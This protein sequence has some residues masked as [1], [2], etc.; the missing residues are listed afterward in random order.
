AIEKAVEFIRRNE[1]SAEVIVVDDGS[2]DETLKIAQEV[3]ARHDNV[4]TLFHW[5]NRG[6]GYAVRRG[7]LNARGRYRMFLDVDLATPIE[8]TGRMLS[9]LEEGADVVV[10]SRHLSESRIEVRQSRIRRWMGGAFRRL[11]RAVLRLPTS[12][13]T[14]G[15]KGF[16]AEAA[17]RIFRAQRMDGWAFDAELI[18]LASA[19]NMKVIELPVRWRDSGDSA[20]RPLSAAR[21]S[22]AAL[23]R[24]WLN[25]RR[26]VYER[27]KADD[28]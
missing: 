4:R 9:A 13:V 25:A 24:L 5:P 10:G 7:M 12:D 18:Y 28:K 23:F 16:R 1:L 14:C 2:D 26:G 6:K 27:P 19:W 8:E 17:E 3:A 22:L 15:F 21:E 11:A 20:V